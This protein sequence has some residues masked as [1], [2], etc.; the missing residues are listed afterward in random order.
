[1][2]QYVKGRGKDEAKIK[3]TR[4]AGRG[5]GRRENKNKGVERIDG[6]GVDWVLLKLIPVQQAASLPAP[7]LEAAVASTI[8]LI[9]TNRP[10]NTVIKLMDPPLC[11]AFAFSSK[12]M[13]IAI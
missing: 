10:I 12:T 3:G 5:W 6:K 9:F 8:I 1:M 11:P 7:Q 13:F 4:M 2:Y